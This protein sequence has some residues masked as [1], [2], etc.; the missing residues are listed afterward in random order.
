MVAGQSTVAPISGSSSVFE[1]TVPWTVTSCACAMIAVTN[2]RIAL[3][4]DLF[5]LL[6]VLIEILPQN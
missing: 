6:L 4:I 1:I 5:M 3:R 2:S